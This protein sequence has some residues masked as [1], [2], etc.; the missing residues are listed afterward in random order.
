MTERQSECHQL[1]TEEEIV[2]PPD[3]VEDNAHEQLEQREKDAMF[4]LLKNRPGIARVEVEYDGFGDDGCITKMTFLDGDGQTV[5][6]SDQNPEDKKILDAVEEY[7]FDTLPDG[8]G[9]D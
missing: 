8:W 4:H 7:V 6:L 5:S 1:D 9:N 2:V 3:L